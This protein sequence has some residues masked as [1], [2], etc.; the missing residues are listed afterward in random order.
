M[1]AKPPVEHLTLAGFDEAVAGGVSVVDFWA[2][3]CAPCRAMAPQLERAAGLRPQYRFAKVD[4]DA[5]P[6]LAD[7]FAIRSIP[8]LMIFRDGRPVAAQ[9]GVIAAEQ[10]VAAVDRSATAPSAHDAQPSSEVGQAA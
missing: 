10:L 8:T 6:E 3:W 5:E 7:R 2:G 1:S 4:V 9:A